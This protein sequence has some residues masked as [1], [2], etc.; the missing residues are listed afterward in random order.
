MRRDRITLLIL[1]MLIV[2]RKGVAYIQLVPGF[3]FTEIFLL[4]ALVRSK[5]P[6]FISALRKPP[7]IM[8]VV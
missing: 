5:G 8:V 1:F 6:T 3:Y 2:G 4:S 7:F